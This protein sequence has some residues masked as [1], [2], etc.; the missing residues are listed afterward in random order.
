MYHS[1]LIH[2]RIETEIFQNAPK[3]IECGTVVQMWKIEFLTLFIMN[4]RL[5]SATTFDDL[6]DII[7]RQLR[8]PLQAQL[9]I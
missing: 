5:H 7:R 6:F 9:Y 3:S 8:R 4:D 2:R 1:N